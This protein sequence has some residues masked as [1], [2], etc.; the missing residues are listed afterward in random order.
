[1]G[2]TALSL[3]VVC[4]DSSHQV[5]PMAPNMCFTPAAPSPLPMPY[6]IMGSTSSLDPGTDKTKIGGKKVSNA[7]SCVAKVNG[8][9]AGVAMTKDITVAG[10]NMG[11][12]WPL[13]VPAV[14]VQFEGKPVTVTTNPGFGNSR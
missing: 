4:E 11:K 1:M 8:N 5:V 7:D 6:P 10:V 9:E 12:A 2:V 14:V 13:P 3:D